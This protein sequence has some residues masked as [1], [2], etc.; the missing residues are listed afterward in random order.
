MRTYFMRGAWLFW[1]GLICG[2]GI[3]A[4]GAQTTDFRSK[5]AKAVSHSPQSDSI[6][7]IEMKDVLIRGMALP[8]GQSGEGQVKVNVRRLEK[9]PQTVGTPDPIR[10]LQ[11]Y[12]GVAAGSDVNT[13]LFVRGTLP[14]QT[15]TL[16]N[17]APLINVMHFTGLYS[18][19]IPDHLEEFTLFKSFVPAKFGGRI[20]GVLEVEPRQGIPEERSFSA[21]LGFLGSNATLRLPLSPT[22]ALTLSARASYLSLYHSISSKMWKEPVRLGYNFG[23]FNATLIKKMSSRDECVFNVYATGDDLSI[24]AEAMDTHSNIYWGNANVSMRW[25]RHYDSGAELR[26]TAYV[27]YTSTRY[28]LK[29]AEQMIF[30][31]SRAL[32]GGIKT[33]FGEFALWKGKAE[34]GTELILR[35]TIPQFLQME[36]ELASSD[37]LK[38][39][40]GTFEYAVFFQWNRPWTAKFSTQLGLRRSGTSY[41]DVSGNWAHRGGWEPRIYLEYRFAPEHQWHASFTMQRQYF[42]QVTVSNMGLP[43][44]YWIP[45]KS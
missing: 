41:R 30:L 16:L 23:D 5:Q 26:N 4:A 19:F 36:G 12:P 40:I 22:L 21:D 33:S 37:S 15:M 3:G 34:A 43:S 35:S 2:C 10:L 38:K 9:L 13:G 17:G 20:G 18:T 28:G 8:I 11:M 14:G 7:V 32:E 29:Q 1:G 24:S 31:D 45:C 42:S 25:S 6:Q 27:T 44:D 39:A